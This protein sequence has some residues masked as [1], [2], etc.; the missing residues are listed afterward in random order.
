MRM[1]ATFSWD[2]EKANDLA[3]KGTLGKIVG[4]ILSDTKPECA[5]FTEVD[6][7]RGVVMVVNLEGLH[8]LPKIAE[9]WFLAFNAKVTVKPAMIAD[10]IAKAE[11]AIAAAAKTYA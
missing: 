4:E 6:G 1:L 5:Y 9:P 8:E 11:P 2:I 7:A 10:D 3:R